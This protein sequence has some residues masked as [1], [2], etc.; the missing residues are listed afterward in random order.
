MNPINYLDVPEKVFGTSGINT[1]NLVYKSVKS[2]NSNAVIEYESSEE[3][4]IIK[5]LAEVTIKEL[6]EVLYSKEQAPKYVGWYP[7]V[8]EKK[9]HK[10]NFLVKFS[11][12]PYGDEP[13][14]SNSDDDFFSEFS[15]FQMLNS[16]PIISSQSISISKE[17]VSAV[18]SSLSKAVISALTSIMTNTKK[19]FSGVWYPTD[20]KKFFSENSKEM[21]VEYWTGY[22]SEDYFNKKGVFTFM[23]K[24]GK[25]PSEAVNT[26]IIGP[27]V[28]D[29]GN[30]TQLAYYKAILDVVGSEKFDVL[31]SDETFKLTIT[32]NGITDSKS[33]ISYFSDYTSASK[34]QLS[35]YI[36]KRP[37]KIGEECHF[38]VIKFYGNKH[39]TGFAGG[40]NVVY[41]GN[42]ELDEQLFVAH[43]FES[44]MTE[45]EINK[46]LVELYNRERTPEEEDYI[47]EN[48]N[49]HAYDRHLNF[50]L[51]N[52]YTVPLELEDEMFDGFLVGSC[53]GLRSELVSRVLEEEIDEKFHQTL[54]CEKLASL[55]RE[56]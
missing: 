52:Y 24:D 27:S 55:A 41:V 51:K 12:F 39:P 15:Y 54:I 19:E 2:I 42:N 33:P 56:L 17:K 32:Q 20:L 29:C 13:E 23:L 37:L 43:G 11:C 46:L 28:L 14:T 3:L 31:F 22:A 26:L 50:Y 21:P 44:P 7:K 40:W 34:K 16:M 8:E 45:K 30:T 47:R 48:P 35:G 6:G 49:P 38:E 36:G 10:G 25:S 9:D 4:I 53:R 5:N 18:E 1:A